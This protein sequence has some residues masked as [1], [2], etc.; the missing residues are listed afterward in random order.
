MKI[1]NFTTLK[2]DKCHFRKQFQPGKSYEASD[3]ICDCKEVEKPIEEKLIEEKLNGR[4]KAT[5]KKNTAS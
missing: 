3:F 5:I 4:R 1:D 2:C